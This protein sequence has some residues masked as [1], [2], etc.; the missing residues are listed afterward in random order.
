MMFQETAFDRALPPREDVLAAIE[1]HV[2]AEGEVV[3]VYER[4]GPEQPLN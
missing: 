3:G 4:P 1:G 2:L